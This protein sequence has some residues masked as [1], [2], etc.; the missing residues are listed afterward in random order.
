MLRNSVTLAAA[1][2]FLVLPAAQAK[3]AKDPD[4]LFQD[5]AVIE[6]LL[7]A[8]FSEIMKQRSTDAEFDGQLRHSDEAGV[9]REFDIKISTRGRYRLRETVCPF[10]PLRLN[11]RK[12]Q[13]DDTLFEKQDKLKLVTHCDDRW[14]RREQL[15]LKEYLAYRILN[16]LTD[17]S[18]RV[19]LLRITYQD[20]DGRKTPYT[21]YGFLVEHK[22]R[23]ARR[24]GLDTIEVSRVLVTDLEPQHMN[25]V[26]VF[27]YLIGNTDF[28]QIVGSRGTC[29]HNHE[30]I[31]E[32]DNPVYSVP[33]DFDQSGIV[34][35]PYASANPRFG[36][37]SVRQRLYRGRC[38]NNGFLDENLE[39]FRQQHDA[40][41]AL[42]DEQVDLLESNR[43]ALSRYIKQ[44]YSFTDSSRN[45]ERRLI[46]RCI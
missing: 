9:N 27:Q 40:I 37:R 35:A 45:V 19:R 34:D 41:L 11:F 3:S 13:T 39:L 42:L 18:F 6:I 15:V 17:I 33:Y 25:L 26:S 20:T 16:Q 22:D 5:S 2:W 32:D 23:L 8:P 44:F 7:V 38:V 29:C 10:A 31:G 12:S 46:R 21:T 43:K 1:A 14:K 24:L 4:P 28:S 30:L 36:L